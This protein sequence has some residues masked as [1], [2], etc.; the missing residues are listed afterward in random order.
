MMKNILLV[1]P[2][3]A[4]FN[5][6]SMFKIPRMGLAILGSLAKAGGYAVRI[7]YEEI[8][9]LKREHILWADLIGFSLTTSTAP[10]GFQL[11][12]N[13]RAVDGEDGKH[14]PIIFGGV[15]STFEPEESL[16]EG[17][18]VMRGEAEQAFPLFL[19]AL[20]G[21]AEVS[22]DFSSVPG[23]VWKRGKETVYNAMPEKR[24]DMKTVPVPDWGLLE[25][26]DIGKS[27]I[28]PVMTSRGCPFDCSFCSVTPM[29]G[30]QYRH[31]S[32]E[33]VIDEL[34]NSTARQVF[35][36]DDHFTADTARSKELLTRIV[37][38]KRQGSITVGGFSAQVRSDI[39]RQPELLDLMEEAG[40]N[41]LFIGFESV[42]PETLKLYKK[43]QRVEDIQ[44]AVREIRKRRIRVHGMFVFGSDADTEE[45]FT[46]TVRF[47][48]KAKIETVQFLIL[49]PLPGS[50]HYKELEAQGRIINSDWNKYDTFNAVYLPKLMTPYRLQKKT[51]TAMRKFYSIFGAL[52]WLFR[53]KPIVTFLRLYGRITLFRWRMNNLKTLR[54]LKSDSTNVFLPEGMRACR[55]AAEAN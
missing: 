29:F 41:T 24:V 34:K 11:A 22:A 19:D 5:I 33:A 54:K 39:A 35:F 42:N 45:T 37:E 38:E 46:A 6:F 17:D 27:N 8:I 47:A 18:F 30:K 48:R 20:F 51:L 49:T 2:K 44:A 23:L 53:G 16:R 7:I 25:G 4:D 13:C 9:S 36:Y 43:G 31:V 15:H 55:P 52:A 1:E 10:R 50:D 14:R 21:G 12:R 3:S 32:V 26:Y 28:S 40:F